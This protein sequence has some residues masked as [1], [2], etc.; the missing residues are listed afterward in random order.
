MINRPAT[1]KT[2]L[3]Q[4][5]TYY[6]NITHTHTQY[7]N[8]RNGH[9]TNNFPLVCVTTYHTVR[10]CNYA[11]IQ[12]YF[13]SW[14]VEAGWRASISCGRHQINHSYRHKSRTLLILHTFIAI[15]R[16]VAYPHP[17]RYGI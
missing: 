4:Y 3:Q 5:I 2:L 15:G 11:L 13:V 16:D 7:T 17:V 14:L 1:T 9:Q 8:K 12:L 6:N 10:N